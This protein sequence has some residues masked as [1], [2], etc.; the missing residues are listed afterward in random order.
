MLILN[1]LKAVYVRSYT[2][3]RFGRIEFVKAHYR[4]CP[5]R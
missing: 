3:K 2:R 4:S 1:W 5:G